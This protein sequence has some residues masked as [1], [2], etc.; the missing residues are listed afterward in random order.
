MRCGGMGDSGLGCGSKCA[1]CCSPSMERGA[2]GCGV[3]GAGRFGSVRTESYQDACWLSCIPC[4]PS[5]RTYTTAAGMCYSP[6]GAV[7]R[8][9]RE[10][11]EEGDESGWVSRVTC[12][13]SSRSA[14]SQSCHNSLCGSLGPSRY[15]T[16]GAAQEECAPG[17]TSR[18]LATQWLHAGSVHAPRARLTRSIETDTPADVLLRLRGFKLLTSQHIG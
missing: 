8:S 5:P 18:D 15:A 10:G 11:K 12:W 17:P 3:W 14:P 4:P 13:I 1:G 6:R 2:L 16:T 9:G 7:G